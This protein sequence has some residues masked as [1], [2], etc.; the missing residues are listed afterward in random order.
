MTDNALLPAR[1]HDLDWLRIF[2]FGLLIFYHIGMFYVTWGWHVKSQHAGTF[3]EPAMQLLN[4][5]RLSLLFLISG[6]ALR[7][8]MDAAKRKKGKLTTFTFKRTLRLLIPIT[9]GMHVIVAPQ[10]WLQLLESGE[11]DLDYATFWWR[12]VVGATDQF[13][14]TTPTWNHLWYVVYLMLYTLLLAP[15]AS[16]LSRWSDNRIARWSATLIG[17]RMG[18][19]V[20]LMLPV[21]P[22]IAYRVWLD[23]HFP[24]TH[25]VIHDWANHA[26]SFTMLLTGFIIAKN[27]VFWTALRRCFPVI[28]V[29]TVLL[30]ITMSTVWANWSSVEGN[31]FWLWVARVGRVVY[32]WLA[33]L[34]L[35][36]AFQRWMCADGPVLRY[37]TEAIFPYYILHQTII[38]M[39]GYWLTRQD[40]PVSVEFAGVL[41]ATV[42][43]CV[44]IH[45]LFI[46]RF[47][48]VR[49]L[50][51]LKMR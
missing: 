16:L 25:D 37:L 44:L 9:F 45:E 40:L 7:Y 1:R 4:P 13:S 21:L 14:I 39:A 28:G 49:P 15:V 23:P 17:T 43:G 2:A 5:W 42:A 24:T 50:F 29:I 18:I 27:A 38:V 22:H 48:W 51:G 6:V 26:H 32:V 12:Y 3:A 31:L 33:I 34:T 47:R 11:I 35:L 8:A 41:F 10:A 19:C 30:A 20:L 36:G 46:R